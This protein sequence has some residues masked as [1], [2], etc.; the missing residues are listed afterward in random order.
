MQL[1]AIICALRAAREDEVVARDSHGRVLAACAP[2]SRV[3]VADLII[4]QWPEQQ[5]LYPGAKVVGRL[6]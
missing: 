2:A 3:P 4:V 1:L 5:R 6:L